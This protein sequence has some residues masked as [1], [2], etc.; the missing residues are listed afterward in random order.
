MS[1]TEEHENQNGET[2][3]EKE[4]DNEDVK[5][6]D[7]E[8]E[9]NVIVNGDHVSDKGDD[10]NDDGG[11]V[12]GDKVENDDKDVCEVVDDNEASNMDRSDII[13][14]ED[15]GEDNLP[16]KTIS[17]TVFFDSVSEEEKQYYEEKAPSQQSLET[18]NINCTACWK[19]VNHHLVNTVMR[20]PI[21]GVAVCKTCFNFYDGDGSD[22][23]WEKDEDGVDLY[24]RWC[25]QGGE[26]LGCDECKYVFCKKCI[27]RNLGRGKFAEIND[28]DKW[29]C[30]CCDPSQIFKERA[31]MF[32]LSKWMSE[33][34]VKNKLKMKLKTEK[35]KT[36]SLK[37]KV[38]QK[39]KEKEAQFE[40]EAS[41]VDNFVDEA[42]H[43]AFETLNIYQKCMQDEQKKWIK[44]RKNMN[45]N[46]TAAIVRSLRK[47]FNITKQNMDLLDTTLVQGYTM[48]YPDESERKIRVTGGVGV[49]LDNSMTTSTPVKTPSKK[50]KRPAVSNTNGDD[51]EVEEIVVNGENVLDRDD[52]DAF[53]PSLLCSVEITAVDRSASSSPELVKRPKMAPQPRGPLKLSNSMFKKKKKTPIKM[54]KARKKQGEIEEITLTD[55]EDLS[56]SYVTQSEI[57]DLAEKKIMDK[58]NNFIQNDENGIDSDVSLE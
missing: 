18:M 12:N 35:K 30:F 45:S 15:K 53:D 21:L 9:K 52:D 57:D 7:Q 32:S 27:T 1:D 34:K 33:L 20:H 13:T 16:S 11:I 28:S 14:V 8:G 44:Q 55:D 36:E 58:A 47:I 40:K 49:E 54:K 46:N 41:K 25:G 37:K 4:K 56:T 50:R 43:E 10:N 2:V 3:E 19:Q 39:K 17:D 48:V 26:V 24:C 31:L 38:E 29:A 6:E 5:A 22:D 51:I 42:F 23:A